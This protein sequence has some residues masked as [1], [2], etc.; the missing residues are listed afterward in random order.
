MAEG[1]SK[2]V[3]REVVADSQT[4]KTER[5]TNTN[6]GTDGQTERDSKSAPNRVRRA[7]NMLQF[8]RLY[9]YNTLTIY[10]VIIEVTALSLR[11]GGATAT[12]VNFYV[13]HGNATGC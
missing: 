4:D 1:Q 5:Q 11:I 3:L 12:S 10:K 7:L 8:R 9:F 6:Y 2:F 13:S